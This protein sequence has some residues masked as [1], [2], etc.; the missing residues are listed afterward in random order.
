MVS[1]ATHGVDVTLDP[2]GDIAD[3][4]I[5][6][7]A[8]ALRADGADL[9]VFLEVTAKKFEDALPD[10]TT[11][12]RYGW[13]HARRGKVEQ[14]EITIDEWIYSLRHVHHGVHGYLTHVVHGIKLATNEVS[15]DE[16]LR[17]LSA[18]LARFADHQARGR[19]ALQRL[20]G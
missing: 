11:V 20:L 4:D 13:L 1:N 10:H 19:D 15:L 6:L 16:W 5:D 9:D 18:A 7:I 12:K 3:E 8:A 14:L 17:A 2:G